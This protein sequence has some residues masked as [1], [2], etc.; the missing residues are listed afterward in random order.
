MSGEIDELALPVLLA[1]STN[2]RGEVMP[3]EY[4]YAARIG[5]LHFADY[6]YFRA[7]GY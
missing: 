5:P 2:L 6:S 3:S 7:Y 4:P 1:S